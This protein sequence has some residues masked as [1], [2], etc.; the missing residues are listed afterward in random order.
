MSD[1]D[2]LNII[3]TDSMKISEIEEIKEIEDFDKIKVLHITQSDRLCS[4]NVFSC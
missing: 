4:M 3:G 2:Q 1:N